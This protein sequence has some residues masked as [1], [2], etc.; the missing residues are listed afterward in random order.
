MGEGELLYGLL[1][2]LAILALVVFAVRSIL[3]CAGSACS[4]SQIS[5]FEE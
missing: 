1:V 5:R 4:S 2:G 3:A